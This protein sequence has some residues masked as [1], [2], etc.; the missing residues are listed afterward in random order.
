MSM[1]ETRAA[2]ET[3]MVVDGD[4]LVRHAIADYLRSC[5]YGVIEAASSDEAVAV[6]DSSETALGAMLCDVKIGGTMSGFELARHA[7]AA[8]PG[9]EVVLAGSIEAI[10]NTAAHLCESGPHLARPYDPQSVVNH[11]KRLFAK[12]NRSR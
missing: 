12:A 1:S 5:G 7:R 6:L 11:I 3:V 4:V 8:R 10:A 9:L 2:T